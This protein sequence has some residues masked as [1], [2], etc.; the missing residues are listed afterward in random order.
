MKQQINYDIGQRWANTAEP[1]LGMGIVTQTEGRMVT[2]FFPD[3]EATRTFA[4]QNAPLIRVQFR[5][6]EAVENLDGESFEVIRSKEQGSLLFYELQN[7][8]G[9]QITLP[10]TQVVGSSENAGPVERLLCGQTDRYKSFSLRYH[11]WNYQKDYATS[12]IHGL[13]GP[14]VDLIP[15]QY[16]IAKEVSQRMEPRVMLAD[17]VGLGKTIEAGLITH[18][19]LSE[20]QIKR[21]LILVPTPLVNQWL[22]EMM[23]RFNLAFRIFNND[24]CEAICESQATNNPFES[25]QLVLC[26]I[27]FLLNNEQWRAKALDADWDLLIVD[28]AH[29]LAWTPEVSSPAYNLVESFSK[30]AKGMLLL[31]ATPEKEGHQ[32]HFAQL[33]LLDPARYHDLNAFIQQQEQFEQVAEAAERLMAHQAVNDD[34]IAILKDLLPD[35]SS[36]QLISKIASESDDDENSGQHK[37]ELANRLLDRQGTGRVLYRNTRDNITDFPVR[38]LHQYPLE[39]PD[40][41]E[42]AGNDLE[43]HLYPERDLVAEQWVFE[44]TRVDWLHSFLKTNRS[45]KVLII[46]HHKDTAIA[47]EQHLTLRAGVLC[48]AFH[49]HLSIIERDRAAAWFAEEETGAQ[50][51]ICSEIGSEGRNF[52]FCHHLVL[53]DLPM[54]V[55]LLEQR[56]GRLDRIGQKQDIQ[57]HAVFFQDTLQ[58][59]LLRWYHQGL[60]AF[61]QTSS[62]SSVVFNHLKD[63]FVNLD[64]DLDDF[65]EKTHKEAAILHEKFIHGRNR[66]LELHS[67]GDKSVEPIL[68]ELRELDYN[69]D[70]SHYMDRLFSQFGV[71]S[72]DLSTLVELVRPGTDLEESFPYVN[73]EGTSITYD[74][75]TALQRDEVQFLTWDH[76]MVQ[77]AM[78]KV[79]TGEKG[80]AS[81]SLLKNKQLKE[82]TLLIELLFVIHCPSPARLGLSRYLPPVPIRILLD[83]QGRNLSEAVKLEVLDK[84]LRNV[85]GELVSAIIKNYRPHIEASVK[86]G[87]TIAQE[88]FVQTQ[89]A[90]MKQFEQQLSAEIQRMTALKEQNPNIDDAEIERLQSNLEEGLAIMKNNAKVLLDAI[91]VMVSVQS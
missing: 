44:D 40:I 68:E 69:D 13:M 25:E 65:I 56:I 74:R 86:Q 49:E 19:L 55:D 1:E 88:L 51:L 31:T 83:Q 75:A 90:S 16:H 48:A 43:S 2:L 22:V 26:S 54:P 10:E 89:Q 82:G 58:E 27:S 9:D 20:G 72:E 70:L 28:E 77:G 4:M 29:H 47:L 52:Q 11:T 38:Q 12:P 42:F 34:E 3:A 46:C 32:S 87:N 17:E 33:H 45:K 78:E 66:L 37:I 57:I 64:G 80:K 62:A 23:R 67:Q 41:Y 84:Q 15:H 59:Q 24:Q 53:F 5:N 71:E 30:Q 6:G 8:A 7:A 36:H 21:V 91:R 14:R 18:K 35:E 50:A 76:P 81:V 85:K 63:D 39:K 73:E 60:N 61:E 79:T